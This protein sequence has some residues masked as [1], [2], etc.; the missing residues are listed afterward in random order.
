MIPLS[1]L[2]GDWQGDATMGSRRRR[3]RTDGEGVR[4]GEARSTLSPEHV[5]SIWLSWREREPPRLGA[6]S[7]MSG[8]PAVEEEPTLASRLEDRQAAPSR[9]RGRLWQERGQRP[10]GVDEARKRALTEDERTAFHDVATEDDRPSW[11]RHSLWQEGA[12]HQL[13]PGDEA[14]GAPAIEEEPTAPPSFGATT[15]GPPRLPSRLGAETGW[16]PE[17]TPARSAAS[18]FTGKLLSPK[19]AGLLL[20]GIV[21]SAAA[22][23]LYISRHEYSMGNGFLAEQLVQDAR[24]NEGDTAA[25]GR[26][27]SALNEE[28]VAAVS[29]SEGASSAAL[30][31]SVF[32]FKSDGLREQQLTVDGC[33]AVVADTFYDAISGAR[34]RLELS[35]FDLQRFR[36]VQSDAPDRLLLAADADA[37][38]GLLLWY[39][40]LAKSTDSEGWVQR[41]L[42][43]ADAGEFGP[44]M[45]RNRHETQIYASDG[46]ETPLP[47]PLLQVSL[48]LPQD[49]A[50][51]AAA[52]WRTYVG[53]H[54]PS[55]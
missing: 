20:I 28:T 25:P 17:S 16:L 35:R 42:L 18:A 15:P 13:M 41:L 39:D 55:G 51:P 34:E 32:S 4:S 38:P 31:E 30:L 47:R 24:T 43:M 49:A 9:H 10:A 22:Y 8:P 46:V 11:H 52:A 21:L 36:P 12:E 5:E 48:R 54:C 1:G 33:D 3:S 27:A 14:W 50:A 2:A 6:A 7:E 53:E 40:A 37:D 23:A 44:F 29:S 45:A 19:L 26:S